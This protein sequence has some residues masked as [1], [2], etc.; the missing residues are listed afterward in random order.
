MLNKRKRATRFEKWVES[1]EDNMTPEVSKK[2]RLRQRSRKG[3]R[4]R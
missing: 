2:R 4:R 1:S 3:K